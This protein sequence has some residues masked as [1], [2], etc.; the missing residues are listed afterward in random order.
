VNQSYNSGKLN[1]LTGASGYLGKAILR[2]SNIEF[3]TLGRS[4]HLDIQIDLSKEVPIIN[5]VDL[6][7]HA[8]GLAHVFSQGNKV[9]NLFYE[10]NLDGTKNLLSSF[11]DNNLPLKFVFISSVSVYGLTSGKLISED[12]P[13]L[14]LDSYGKSKIEAENLIKNWCEKNNVICTILRLPLVVASSPPGNLGAMIQGIKNGFY[15][16]ISG[17]E[18]RK[19]MVLA[20]DV[21]N[22]L[23]KA[24]NVGG[25]YNL[26]DGYHPNFKELSHHIAKQTG[27]RYILNMP[28]GL[29]RILAFI[30]DKIITKFPLNS[31]KLLKI[32]STLT[33]DD[34]KA[35]QIF[36]WNPTSVLKGFNINE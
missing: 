25:T 23:F 5:N 33:F 31:N 18:A 9:E 17:G 8:A 34:S 29:A 35:R 22:F 24:A 10:V 30:G 3:V 32:S 4:R 2:Y 6:V 20:S 1:I 11:S 7:V 13:L 15:F 14:A 12:A 27:N 36:G 19:S 21:A 28:M 26:T 16:N